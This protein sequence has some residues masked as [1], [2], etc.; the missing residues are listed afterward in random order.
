MNRICQVLGRLLALLALPCVLPVSQAQAAVVGDVLHTPAMRAPQ[1]RQA[2]LLD[3]ARAGARL[4]AVGERGIVLLSDDNGINWRQAQVPVSVS[5]TAVQFVDA[6]TGWAVGHA[7]AVLVSHDGGENWELQLDG[8]RAAQL[9][10]HGAREQLPTATDPDA[11]AIHLAVVLPLALLF[12]FAIPSTDE[13]TQRKQEIA[14]LEHSIAEL[15]R[16]G[17]GVEIVDCEGSPCVRTRETPGE[18][19]YHDKVTGKKTYRLVWVK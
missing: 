8:N 14:T 15:K 6:N 9:E 10:L 4:V 17:G 2:V 1:A 18:N 7:G 19:P 5:L 13:I 16:Q 11:A 3:L 12:F